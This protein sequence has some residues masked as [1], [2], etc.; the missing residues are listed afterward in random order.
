MKMNATLALGIAAAVGFAADAYDVVTNVAGVVNEEWKVALE[1]EDAQERLTADAETC[2]NGASPVSGARFNEAAL[3]ASL[4]LCSDG[5]GVLHFWHD[6]GRIDTQTVYSPL[7]GQSTAA[8]QGGRESGAEALLKGFAMAFS[9]AAH[10]EEPVRA[11]VIEARIT[12][13]DVA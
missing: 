2:V 11:S 7:L 12:P 10:A 8:A 3:F 1:R 9:S 13:A 5:V 6:D 4:Y